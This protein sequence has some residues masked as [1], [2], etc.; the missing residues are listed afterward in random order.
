MNQFITVPKVFDMFIILTDLTRFLLSFV[1]WSFQVLGIITM[2]E[3]IRRGK[4]LRL[5]MPKAPQGNIL[6]RIMHLSLGMP[7]KASPLSSQSIGMSLEV[8]FLFVTWYELYLERHLLLFAFIFSLPQS[9]FAGH[10]YLRETHLHH[11][12][13]EYSMR[14]TYIFW[15]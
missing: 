4:S 8:I 1:C 12:L 13:L 3:G 5:G 11:N 2:D 10:T 6:G 9:S 7:R 14:F 15:A